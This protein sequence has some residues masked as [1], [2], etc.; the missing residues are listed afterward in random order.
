MTSG[1]ELATE[2]FTEGGI[3]LEPPGIS[4]SLVALYAD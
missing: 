2:V 3:W 1:G 4:V